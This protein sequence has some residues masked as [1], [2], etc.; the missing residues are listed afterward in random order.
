MPKILN[1]SEANSIGL[2]SMAFLAGRPETKITTRQIAERLHVSEAHLAKVLQRLTKAGLVKAVRGPK[3]GFLLNRNPED[4]SLI[5][6]FEAIEGPLVEA[7]CLLENPACSGKTCVLGGLMGAVNKQVREYF[8][9]TRL[10]DII[11]TF[12]QTVGA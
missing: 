2:H 5:D 9:N 3:G 6:I 7:E 4:I 8:V 12:D 1:I 10:S 11:D